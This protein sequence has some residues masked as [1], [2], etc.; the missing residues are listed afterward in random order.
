MRF[1]K[2]I[3]ML[4]SVRSQVRRLESNEDKLTILPRVLLLFSTFFT[5]FGLLFLHLTLYLD[6][7]DKTY[8]ESDYIFSFRHQSLICYRYHKDK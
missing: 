6:P 4:L 2:P 3:Y 1:A 8:T 5:F 7:L